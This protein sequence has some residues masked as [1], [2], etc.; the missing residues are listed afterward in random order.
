M[1]PNTN[2]V[3][4]PLII[5]PKVRTAS[6]VVSS[7]LLA[8]CAA[9]SV[10]YEDVSTRYETG[11]EPGNKTPVP[12]I[13]TGSII[14]SL[15]KTELSLVA[16]GSTSA[17]HQGQNQPDAGQVGGGEAGDNASPKSQCSSD[18]R[19][20]LSNVKVSSKPIAGRFT[21]I[22][23]PGGGTLLHGS[24]QLSSTLLNQDEP[25]LPKTVTVNW[26]NTGANAAAV[27][28]VAFA[29]LFSF[30]LVPAL[31]G[32]AVA[33]GA[34]LEGGHGGVEGILGCKKDPDT[35]KCRPGKSPKK[36]SQPKPVTLTAIPLEMIC[37]HLEDSSDDDGSVNDQA[38]YKQLLAEPTK[39]FPPV[40]TKPSAP[41]D[42]ARLK[43]DSFLLVLKHPE[44]ARRK[45]DPCWHV[46]RQPFPDPSLKDGRGSPS[47][48][49]YRLVLK[50]DPAGLN[51]I[52]IT[53]FA[54]V[55][56]S[57]P[58]SHN[59]L[60]QDGLPA[61]RCLSLEIQMVWWQVPSTTTTPQDVANNRF[62]YVRLPSVD[63]VDPT[64]AQIIPL[65]ANGDIN[66]GD[67]CG[68]NAT[69]KGASDVFGDGVAAVF[70][71][72][73]EGTGA[74]SKTSTTK[75]SSG[76]GASSG[77]TSGGGGASQ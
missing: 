5:G 17:S 14:Y 73:G 50:D 51:P 66:F 15:P 47:G 54:K 20:C 11:Q 38:D 9:P 60:T 33:S 26:T 10:T 58:D 24:T 31:V 76:T 70:K 45:S 65:P 1:N 53:S 28:G 52:L 57:R 25:R 71:S 2:S 44:P 62:P 30:G 61:S 55:D 27:G 74:G 72:V 29:G 19:M 23:R 21:W 36:S 34:E 75:N 67:Y 7:V 42:G 68:A 12:S 48:W 46:L 35:G 4:M 8:A 77:G 37:S 22:V 32:A 69:I 49:L 40:E 64:Y 16:S 18:F 3:N 39:Q 59:E 41:P 13:A 6:A 63:I 56:S 43:T